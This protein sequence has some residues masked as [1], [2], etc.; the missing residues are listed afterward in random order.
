MTYITQYTYYENNGT[1]PTDSLQGSYQYVSLQ[2]IVNNFMLSLFLGLAPPHQGCIFSP[3][4][5]EKKSKFSNKYLLA[6]DLDYFLSV[7]NCTNSF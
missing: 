7:S 5:L 2:D 3:N 6:S 4:I 1:V